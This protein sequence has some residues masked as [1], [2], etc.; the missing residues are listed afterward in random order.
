MMVKR[1][2]ANL[3][4]ANPLHQKP[5]LTKCAGLLQTPLKAVLEVRWH[6]HPHR[7]PPSPT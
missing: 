1:L 3:V 2:S 7:P 5:T 4:A 6:N